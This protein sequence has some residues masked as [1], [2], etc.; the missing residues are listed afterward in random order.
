MITLDEYKK[1][2]I[3]HYYHLCDAGSEKE[4]QRSINLATY[5]KDEL[6]QRI[7]D[8]TYSFVEHLFNSTAI[9]DGYY[10]EELEDDVSFYIKLGLTGGHSSD[11]IIVDSNDQ[12]ISEY[13]MRK[14]FGNIEFDVEEDITT[15]EA[16]SHDDY[17]VMSFCS[18]IYLYIQS[19]PKNIDEIKDR[20]LKDKKILM[21]K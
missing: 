15:Y 14:I 21:K 8:N 12:M 5:Y 3:E 18:R 19:F 6:L 20:F 9:E 4:Y 2:L 11:Y 7:I 17:D 10:Y 1:A 16:E 13:I